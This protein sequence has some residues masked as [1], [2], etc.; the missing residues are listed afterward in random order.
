MTPAAAKQKGRK[1]QQDIRDLL[2][3]HFTALTTR[4][5][6]STSMGADGEDLQLSE[7]AYKALN[8]IVIECKCLG[9]LDTSKVYGALK[10]CHDHSKDGLHVVFMRTNAKGPIAIL[11]AEEFITFLKSKQ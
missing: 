10:Q 7:T 6:R 1:F 2:L 8:N 5:I 3:K 9:S 4:D 11:D